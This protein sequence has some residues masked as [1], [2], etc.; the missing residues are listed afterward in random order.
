MV[1]MGSADIFHPS[2]IHFV[3]SLATT[4]VNIEQ[5][6]DPFLVRFAGPQSLTRI[7][8]DGSIFTE[9]M[10]SPQG[11]R[12]RTAFEP[13][14]SSKIDRCQ[15]AFGMIGSTSFNCSLG[16]KSLKC[17]EMS[18]PSCVALA[19][20]SEPL[21]LSVADT[22]TVPTTNLKKLHSQGVCPTKD[23]RR[24]HYNITHVLL[25]PSCIDSVI[26]EEKLHENAR[27]MWLDAIGVPLAVNSPSQEKYSYI[28]NG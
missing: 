11:C 1:W 12:K 21:I 3:V 28:N 27:K 22:P 10:R 20:G 13:R 4:R 7:D 9:V 14:T 5:S 6:P 17:N 15:W 16:D 19:A 26:I 23:Y 2:Y 8:I 25:K 24:K 18:V